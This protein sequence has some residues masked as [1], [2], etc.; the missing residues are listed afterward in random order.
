MNRP[1]LIFGFRLS[2]RLPSLII[3]LWIMPVILFTPFRAMVSA[4]AGRALRTI[5]E[6]FTPPSGDIG[7][8]IIQALV[9][10]LPAL[11]IAVLG[12]L[13]L[14]WTWNILWHAGLCRWLIWEGETS[15]SL[16]RILGHGLMRWVAYLRLSLW[17][18]LM[19]FLFFGGLG[20]GFF[21]LIRQA[22]EG[23]QEGRMVLL[24]MIALGVLSLA[25]IILWAA[26]LR[27]AWELTMPGRRSSVLAWSRGLRGTLRQPLATLLPT[28]VLGI[29]IAGCLSLPLLLHLSVPS[30]RTGWQIWVVLAS[31][32]LVAAFL[33][34]WLFASM[35][36]IT[37]LLPSAAQIETK[38]DQGKAREMET[39]RDPEQQIQV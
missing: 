4:S 14:M 10:M 12:S 33:Q 5:P 26:T 39:K 35:A 27:G 13:F 36:P 16:F 31:S 29:L 3:A 2:L 19:F 11:A 37:G 8:L 28:A 7:L 9:P 6:A 22:W 34:L 30:Y 38:V 15:S 21:V 32:S 20:A 18:W 17:A 1:S 24:I 25:K 23:M